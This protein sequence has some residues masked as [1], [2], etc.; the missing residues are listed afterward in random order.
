MSSELG[1]MDSETLV[2][3]LKMVCSLRNQLGG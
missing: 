1:A 3:D 2:E